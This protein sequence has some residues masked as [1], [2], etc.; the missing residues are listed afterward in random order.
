LYKLV[1]SVSFVLVGKYIEVRTGV[2]RYFVL[3]GK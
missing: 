2:N 3:T 1:S